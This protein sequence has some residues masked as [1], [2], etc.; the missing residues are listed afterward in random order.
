MKAL[1]KNDTWD[2]VDLL[3]G[4]EPVACKW[5]FSMKLQLDGP[6]KR[7]EVRLVAKGSSTYRINYQ[8][9]FV[10][11]AKMNSI[12]VL[13]SLAANLFKENKRGIHI[14][15]ILRENVQIRGGEQK[16]SEIINDFP[17]HAQVVSTMKSHGG[18]HQVLR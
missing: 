5:V 8:E 2:I 12:R 1:E 17:G 18:L 13:I 3:K 11:V 16:S 7:Y 6:V 10:S 4:K 14:Q 15:S 9:T